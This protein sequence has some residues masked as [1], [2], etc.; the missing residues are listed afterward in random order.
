M[1]DEIENQE[2]FL[3]GQEAYE[4]LNKG[5]VERFQFHLNNNGE[6]TDLNNGSFAG[7]FEAHLESMQEQMPNDLTVREADI[8]K[9]IKQA[10]FGANNFENSGKFA[11]DAMMKFVNKD[12][13][14]KNADG[15]HQQLNNSLMKDFA[16]EVIEP[17]EM[18]IIRK[19]GG[20]EEFEKIEALE[21]KNTEALKAEED[22]LK[23]GT[24]PTREVEEEANI[25]NY[26]IEK[27]L[28]NEAAE[29]GYYA[30]IRAT[31]AA[32]K[33]KKD[34]KQKEKDEKIRDIALD[35]YKT[36][37]KAFAKAGK[38]E[39]FAAIKESYKEIVSKMEKVPTLSVSRATLIAS[40]TALAAKGDGA[41]QS[42][43]LINELLH[44]TEKK[45]S[46]SVY[47]DFSQAHQT[48]K[49]TIS[50]D[51]GK[52]KSDRE[53]RKAKAAGK[54]V[55]ETKPEKKTE[56]KTDKSEKEEPA[57][58]KTPKTETKKKKEPAKDTRSFFTK[59]FRNRTVEQ[60]TQ[61]DRLDAVKESASNNKKLSNEKRKILENRIDKLKKQVKEGSNPKKVTKEINTLEKG[62]KRFVK[63]DK[64]EAKESKKSKKSK[65]GESRLAFKEGS[66]VEVGGVVVAA[67]AGLWASLTGS[68]KE[69][70]IDERRN[71]VPQKEN[72]FSV[73]RILGLAALGA[74]A[75]S[76]YQMSQGNSWTGKVL[77]ERANNQNKGNGL[78]A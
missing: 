2:T 51:R 4:R 14:Y 35:D 45:V 46:D 74:A 59:I 7:F 28:E 56:P 40:A 21:A 31:E 61:L 64:N 58:A 60:Q 75:Y 26:E 25:E 57:E 63:I 10:R 62:H 43:A 19:K 13:L 42:A 72:F 53:V 36:I 11:K 37:E 20:I 39:Q 23:Y 73:K 70:Q 9:I 32:E 12:V 44:Q 34:A 77:N 76:G 38:E 52:I 47:T 54:A 22:R 78:G 33:I 71:V 27:G 55:E 1:T 18:A 50:L 24:P 8:D 3:T 66:R 16:K 17:E 49:G 15:V 41:D 30:E 5:L 69:P 48:V 65:K 67:V 29:E 68:K 6:S